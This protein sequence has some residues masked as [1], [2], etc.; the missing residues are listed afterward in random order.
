VL[1]SGG[2]HACDVG[3]PAA[4]ILAGSLGDIGAYGDEEFPGPNALVIAGSMLV[5]ANGSDGL[6]FVD[7]SDPRAMSVIGELPVGRCWNVVLDDGIAYGIGRNL[8]VSTGAI[9]P[10]TQ[11]TDISTINLR[12]Y[13]PRLC[14]D[15]G[16]QGDP[17]DEVKQPSHRP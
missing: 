15:R 16:S 9:R 3:D 6:P 14:P 7:I 12:L 1:E 8:E 13:C 10:G 4:S 11:P 5:V 2:L 17:V